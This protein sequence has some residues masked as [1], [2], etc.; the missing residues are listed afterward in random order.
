MITILVG[1]VI[2]IRPVEGLQTASKS[3]E[4]SITRSWVS[5]QPRAGRSTSSPVVRSELS[6]L[7]DPGLTSAKYLQRIL[8]RTLKSHPNWNSLYT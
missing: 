5:D 6:D 2:Y 8:D 7:M 4:I 1:R 3:H